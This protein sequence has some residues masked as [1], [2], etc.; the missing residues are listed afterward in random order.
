MF[1]TQLFAASVTIIL[2]ACF[3]LLI[4]RTTIVERKVEGF[5]VRQLVLAAEP[6]ADKIWRVVR[7]VSRAVP[8]LALVRRGI[9][10]YVAS[11][12]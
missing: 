4:V 3:V 11:A 1:D 10:F 2:P 5:A 7:L 6:I 8:M 9:L 12:N